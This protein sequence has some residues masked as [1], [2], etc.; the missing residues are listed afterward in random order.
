[1]RLAIDVSPL[2][3]EYVTGVERTLL[4]LLNCLAERDFKAQLVAPCLPMLLKQDR[5]KHLL[6]SSLI[7]TPLNCSN[8]LWRERAVP[9]FCQD[10]GIQLWHSHVQAI[11][12][13][14]S[15][16][17]I[18]TMHELSW[19]DSKD[20]ADEGSIIKRKLFAKIVARC[21]DKII[22]VSDYT[23]NNFLLENPKATDKTCV[24]HHSV[25]EMFFQTRQTPGTPP[26]FLC[27][28]RP[29]KRKAYANALRA[30]AKFKS[31]SSNLQHLYFAGEHNQQMVALEQ[32]AKELNIGSAVSFLGHVSD[33][34]LLDLY[35]Q[36][37]L[38]LMPSESEGFGIPALEAMASGCPVVSNNCGALQEVC[39]GA[40]MICDFSDAANTATVFSR[41]QGEK[42][43]LSEHG[44]VN[45]RQYTVAKTVDRLISTWEEFSA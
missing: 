27:V 34:D 44:L 29:L 14:A 38:L 20:V 30:F 8:W 13:R 21:A 5:F 16:P 12:L 40:A 41:A 4:Q 2:N 36:A 10:S 19:L 18:A 22:C 39:A 6:N 24:I 7:F 31:D 37:D 45:A 35:A 26:F 15:C 25:D 42:T 1:L 28:G 9:K 23:R 11:P 33:Q 3:R 32:L 17:K 43:A